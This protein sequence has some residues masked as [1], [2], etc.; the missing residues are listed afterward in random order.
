MKKLSKQQKITL[1][2]TTFVM[3]V[4]GTICAVLFS[5]TQNA[6]AANSV[7]DVT[8]HIMVDE[9]QHDPTKLDIPDWAILLLEIVVYIVIAAL[10]LGI[11]CYAVYIIGWF[12][13]RRSGTLSAKVSAQEVEHEGNPN[14]VKLSI[15]EEVANE[16]SN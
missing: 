3:M 7:N 10:G 8:A 4:V 6:P 13:K 1:A 11:I 9:V 16:K 2:L 15:G 14:L 5:L 12:I